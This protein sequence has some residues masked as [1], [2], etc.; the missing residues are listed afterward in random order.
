VSALLKQPSRREA[1]QKAEDRDTERQRRA[2]LKQWRRALY[3]RIADLTGV[4]FL[5][6]LHEAGPLR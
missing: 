5:T 6:D 2:D 4:K 3:G 1:R